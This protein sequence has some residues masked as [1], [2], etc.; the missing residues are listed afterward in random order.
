MSHEETDKDLQK[1]LAKGNVNLSKGA[2]DF[3]Q[4]EQGTYM[5]RDGKITEKIPVHEHDA[6]QRRHEREVEG[7]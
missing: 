5:F 7:K 1:Q 3:V 2:N 4:T 6:R